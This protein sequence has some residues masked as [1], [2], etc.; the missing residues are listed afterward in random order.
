MTSSE[1]ELET[2]RPVAHA[3]DEIPRMEPWLWV[4]LS[5][6]APVLLAFVL[7]RAMMGLLFG[8]SGLLLLVGLVLFVAHERRNRQSRSASPRS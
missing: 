1:S 6:L 2:P 3:E 7:P 8:V 5:A 4:L